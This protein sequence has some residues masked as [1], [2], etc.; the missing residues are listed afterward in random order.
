[1]IVGR[2]FHHSVLVVD[3]F[4]IHSSG[5]CSVIVLVGRFGGMDI[6]LSYSTANDCFIGHTG[7]VAR[8]T[9]Q[10]NGDC[11]VTMG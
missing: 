11:S 6:I 9:I 7:L 3:R 4:T 2:F 5:D 10:L 1:M 8:V